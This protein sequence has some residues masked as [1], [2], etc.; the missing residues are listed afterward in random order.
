MDMNIHTAH[1]PMAVFPETGTYG[2]WPEPPDL[3][4]DPRIERSPLEMRIRGAIKRALDDKGYAPGEENLTFQVR[5]CV[6]L[7]EGTGFASTDS[8][9][10][11]WLQ[12]LLDK[13]GYEK[14]T[15]VIELLAPG[16]R[17]LTWCAICEAT[18]VIDVPEAEKQQRVYDAVRLMFEGFPPQT[19]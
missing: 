7:G 2:W 3:P 5:F 11:E 13:E 19:S 14:G 1:D 17:H 18:V 12:E 16:S 4:D 9:P 6:N 8:S 10:P 15:M